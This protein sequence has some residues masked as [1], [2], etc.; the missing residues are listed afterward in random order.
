M[1]SSGGAAS[2]AGYFFIHTLGLTSLEGAA[3]AVIAP[4]STAV[5]GLF[6]ASF[7][8]NRDYF[9]RIFDTT[10][11]WSGGFLS[12]KKVAEH[13]EEAGKVFEKEN[14]LE[15]KAADVATAVAPNGYLDYPASGTFHRDRVIAASQK[16]LV[17][18]D[19]TRA[20]PH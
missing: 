4:L 8:I 7:G 19:Q 13:Q 18:L 1:L 10:D 15:H 12:H 3:A 17:D 5:M 16:A 20:T 6:G 11:L 9:R 2:I 14:G